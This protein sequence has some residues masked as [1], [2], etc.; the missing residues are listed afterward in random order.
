MGAL[1]ARE[2][3][4]SS[5]RG[6]Q[7]GGICV[8]IAYGSMPSLRFRLYIQATRIRPPQLQ[9]G[10]KDDRLVAAGRL[11]GGVSALFLFALCL[12]N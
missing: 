11:G 10:V 9:T 5:P 8:K 7:A 2:I 12:V 1:V 4:R 6:H 3:G